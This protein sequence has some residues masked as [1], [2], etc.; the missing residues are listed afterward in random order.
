MSSLVLQAVK[1]EAARDH[2]HDLHDDL[3]DQGA[4]DQ[5]A[6][7]AAAEEERARPAQLQKYQARI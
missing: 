1:Y 3:R 6:E 4:L 2:R 7:V 5:M